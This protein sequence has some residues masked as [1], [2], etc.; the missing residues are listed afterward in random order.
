MADRIFD[1]EKLDVYWLAIEYVVETFQIA[2]ELSGLPRHSGDQWLRAA[3]SIPINIAEGNGNEA[4][5][6]V[7]DSSNLPVARLWSV[8]RSTM[9]YW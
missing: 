6:T 4:S 5:R 9:C 8:R 1:H 3:Q 7:L 2:K